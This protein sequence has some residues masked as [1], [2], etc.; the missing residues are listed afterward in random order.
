[1]D[2][3]T[4]STGSCG[5]E[6]ELA[7]SD[8]LHSHTF[9][10][11]PCATSRPDGANVGTGEVHYVCKVCGFHAYGS[12]RGV[13]VFSTSINHGKEILSCNEMVVKDILV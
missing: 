6:E 4:K 1:M 13:T 7:L 9:K 8:K 5:V 10:R 12:P 2:T 11:V 3:T